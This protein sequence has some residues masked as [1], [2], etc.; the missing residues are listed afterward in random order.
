MKKPTIFLLM[1]FAFITIL[2]AQNRGIFTS[3]QNGV[4][5][6]PATWGGTTTPS[7]G[8]EVT[9]SDTVQL[10]TSITG[11]GLAK[12]TVTSTG[13]L[14]QDTDQTAGLIMATGSTLTVDGYMEVNKLEI[15]HSFLSSETITVNGT[16]II[17]GDFKRGGSFINPTPVT[18]DGTV[19]A[20]TYTNPGF[21]SNDTIFGVPQSDL[22]DGQSYGGAT[23]KGGSGWSG[24]E[25]WSKGSNWYSGSVPTSSQDVVIMD[26]SYEPIISSSGMK[27]ANS[28]LIQHGAS[29]TINSSANLTITDTTLNGIIIQSDSTESGSLIYY[30]NINGVNNPK[31]TAQRYVKKDRWNM[32]SPSTT[33]VTGQTFYGTTDSDSWL[34]YFVESE[35]A[36]GGSAGDGWHFITNVNVSD[37]VGKG[38]TYWP[39]IDETVEFKGELRS[40]DISPNIAYS[41]SGYG[42]NLL[43]NPFSSSLLWDGS[44]AWGLSN[45]ESTIWIWDGSQYQAL[46]SG[47]ASYTIAI[48]QGF[49]VRATGTNPTLTIPSSKRTVSGSTFLKSS[50]VQD[51]DF[52]HLV[53]TVQNNQYKDEVFIYFDESGTEDF[54]NGYDATKMF[55]LAEAPQIYLVE[56]DMKLTYDFLPEV[57]EGEERTVALN[58]IPGAA[59]EQ[60]LTIDYSDLSGVEVTLEDLLTGITQNL[61]SKSV[62][63]F[64]GLKEDDPN[65][66]LLHFA[67][68]PN[69][70]EE[71]MEK[72]SSDIQIYS[73]NKDVY[74]RS[75]NQAVN[76]TGNVFVYDMMGRELLQK[77]ID[78]SELVKLPVNIANNY[79]IVKVVK[80]GSIKTQKVFIK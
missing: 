52:N 30:S 55:G 53:I 51:K 3:V 31:A 42:Y 61:N 57:S 32:V 58:Y 22:E 50:N 41:G 29:L 18:G 77:K 62:Y 75:V 40:T 27:Y 4:W 69:G 1:F 16:L 38:Y 12:L 10:D 46:P 48:G 66:F 79:V 20:E 54:D 73:Y 59:G 67:W 68:S 43:G 7:V 2:S 37:S 44:T 36:D 13:S 26:R 49:F 64:T 78:G 60:M 76:Q 6:D 70:I 23:W 39:T 21:G 9:I 65:R 11:N 35:G 8:D 72:V 5:T 34:T 19:S 33:D 24:K 28:L 71:E 74:I 45:M 47:S 63:S 15:K 14:I 80:S 56:N 25:K 17:H